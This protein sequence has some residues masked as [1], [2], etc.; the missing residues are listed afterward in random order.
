M[1]RFLIERAFGSEALIRGWYSDYLR[2]DAYERKCGK[3]EDAQ[4]S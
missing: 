3:A 2:T 1:G 4:Y